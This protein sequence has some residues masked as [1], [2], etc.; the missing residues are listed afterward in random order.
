MSI[1]T[2]L[3]AG[4]QMKDPR[5]G[6]GT[7]ESEITITEIGLAAGTLE[8]F[9]HDLVM[10]AHCQQTPPNLPKTLA[11]IERLFLIQWNKGKGPESISRK[12]LDKIA[13]TLWH[14]FA[15]NGR[16][17]DYE[18]AFMVG[19]TDRHWRRGT[20]E[21]YKATMAELSTLATKAYRDIKYQLRADI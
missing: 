19:M 2:R 7:S 20:N 3:T 18:R 6:T 9:S 15:T 21:V 17:T 16:M 13:K 5:E 12:R 4:S 14:D 1:L 10:Q 8:W 11:E